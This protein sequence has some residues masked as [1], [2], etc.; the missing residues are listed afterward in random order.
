MAGGSLPAAQP[1]NNEGAAR[2][3]SFFVA[4]VGSRCGRVVRRSRRYRRL[5]PSDACVL[6]GGMQ[7]DIELVDGHDPVGIVEALFT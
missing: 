2:G 7:G 4:S 6:G 5:I 1:E 3:R